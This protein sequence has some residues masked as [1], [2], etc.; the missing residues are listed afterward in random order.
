MNVRL[1]IGHL[2]FS[3]TSDANIPPI[4]AIYRWSQRSLFLF[5]QKV[6]RQAGKDRLHH[7]LRYQAQYLA[8]VPGRETN[9]NGWIIIA[10]NNLPE[11]IDEVQDQTDDNADD[12][13]R[14]QG[15]VKGEMFFFDQEVSRQPS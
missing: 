11:F 1:S 8:H 3:L 9:K 6:R 15:E 12:D 4:N 2:T 5:Y 13:A 14:G 10:M 7:G